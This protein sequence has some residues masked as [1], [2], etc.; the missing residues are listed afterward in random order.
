MSVPNYPEHLSQHMPLA[1]TPELR[2]LKILFSRIFNLAIEWL[3]HLCLSAFGVFA[4]V[5]GLSFPPEH[6]AGRKLAPAEIV[7]ELLG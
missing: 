1:I 5:C 7:S 3:Y 2:G 6:D 4:N